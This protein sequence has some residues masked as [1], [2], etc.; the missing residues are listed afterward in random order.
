MVKCPFQSV[1]GNCLIAFPEPYAIGGRGVRLDLVF[2]KLTKL[3]LA[4]RALPL[5][6]RRGTGLGRGCGGGGGGG[7]IIARPRIHLGLQPQ[8]CQDLTNTFLDLG[9]KIWI[10]CHGMT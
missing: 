7:D 10:A 6:G 5:L 2:E 8:V 4:V 1:L 9:T 3:L